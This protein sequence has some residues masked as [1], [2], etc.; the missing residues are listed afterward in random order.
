MLTVSDIARFIAAGEA[1]KVFYKL[2]PSE[3]KGVSV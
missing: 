1:L 2:Q 3:L